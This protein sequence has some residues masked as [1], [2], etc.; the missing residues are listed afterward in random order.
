MIIT[1]RKIT[2][3]NGTDLNLTLTLCIQ[4]KKTIVPILDDRNRLQWYQ[5][6][7][8]MLF[9]HGLDANMTIDV[10]ENIYGHGAESMI[11][12]DLAVNAIGS[13]Y[14]IVYSD[15]PSVTLNGSEIWGFR[16]YFSETRYM[17][18]GALSRRGDLNQFWYFEEGNPL[19]LFKL[20]AN[21]P[22]NNYKLIFSIPWYDSR[23]RSAYTY[24]MRYS[25]AGTMRPEEFFMQAL[26]EPN[27]PTFPGTQPLECQINLNPENP[28]FGL[29]D[30]NR[31]YSTISPSSEYDNDS[32]EESEGQNGEY[33]DNSDV[34][35][36]DA[37]PEGALNSSLINNFYLGGD[38]HQLG[39]TTLE[40]KLDIIGQWLCDFDFDSSFSN[41]MNSLV[42][43]KLFFSSGDPDYKATDTTAGHL[44]VGGS[45]VKHQYPNGNKIVNACRAKQ[46]TQ[47]KIV[48]N[49][50][51]QRY[52]GNF[53][54]YAPHTKIQIYLP[55]CGIQEL[56][57]S[58]VIDKDLTIW[59]K[60][61][62]VTGD[63]MYTIHS[64][65]TLIYHFTGNACFD[66][67]MSAADYGGKVTSLVSTAISA[68]ASAA[69]VVG[70]AFSGN[71]PLAL[72]GVMGLAGSAANVATANQKVGT[73]TKGTLANTF[74]MMDKLQPYLIITR[75]VQ[76]KATS[77]ASEK[78]YPSQITANLGSVR[79]FCTIAE[80]KPHNMPAVPKEVID[81]LDT[82][83]KT[84]GII[85]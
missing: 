38:G 11:D 23:S 74:S 20:T 3:L 55:F 40:E 63:I 46:F 12:H 10:E 84:E 71:A 45:E 78:G 62:W 50:R 37:V 29:D 85:L 51:V 16:F 4:E 60:T 77:Y 6:T 72:S 65:G 83:V 54:D 9:E 30:V 81:R 31:F 32:S 8:S 21:I 56:D 36:N 49:F 61:D 79:G 24:I 7:Q 17:I 59:L 68:A 42:S 43:L 26:V 35:G 28:S 80:W 15:L 25:Y 69:S 58:L 5:D 75:P 19:W 39:T 41:R 44:I 66:I 13:N 73:Y 34:I 1:S 76:V 18:M 70:G 47:K 22:S 82:L 14:P 53:L 2:D 48:E 33:N 67:P 27:D 57:P 64:N 52:F